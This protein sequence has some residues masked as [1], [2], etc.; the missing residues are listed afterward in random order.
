[1]RKVLDVR[2]RER[3]KVVLL[4]EVKDGR[5][6]QLKDEA[7]V[8]LVVKHLS[9][10]DAFAEDERKWA[11]VGQRWAG[12]GARPTH[13]SLYGSP[14]LSSSRTR[15]SILL[16]SRYFWTARMILT[17]YLRSGL[18]RSTHSTTLPKVPSPSLRTIR[19]AGK[20]RKRS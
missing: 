3:D 12:A 10:V 8:V 14:R 16:A 6:E 11:S 18:L 4:E 15:I 17:A 9:Q 5:A 20:E 2:H 7:D 19:S 13:F 1:V